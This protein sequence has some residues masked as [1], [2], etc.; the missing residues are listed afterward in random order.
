VWV[1]LVPTAYFT[2]RGAVLLTFAPLGRFTVNQLGAML[3]FLA[4]GFGVVAAKL[5]QPMRHGLVGVTALLAVAVPAWMGMVT[6]EPGKP[7]ASTLGPV[8]PVSLNPP[9]MMNVARWL[10]REVAPRTGAVV[11]DSQPQ[12][13][14]IQLAFYSGL[15]EERIER[16]RWENLDK[17]MADNAPEYLV[18]VEGGTLATRADYER[19]DGRV[20]LADFWFDE[21]PGFGNKWHVYRRVHSQ[22]RESGMP[23]AREMRDSAY[24]GPVILPAPP[25]IPA[26]AN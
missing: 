2:F 21:V 17:L 5:S 9:D 18:L 3:P 22:E 24:D 16:A 6:S 11:I 4:V 20:Q 26:R 12:Y 15:R 25:P 23:T 8:S 19:R 10:K 7:M 13:E 14:D 1:V